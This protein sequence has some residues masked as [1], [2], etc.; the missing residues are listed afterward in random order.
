MSPRA[1]KTYIYRDERFR[2]SI[3]EATGRFRTEGIH[4]IDPYGRKFIPRGVNFAGGP[5]ANGGASPDL[6]RNAEVVEG[7]KAWGGNMIR[8]T[9]YV[10]RR[11]SW[12]VMGEAL[13]A[14]KAVAQATAEVDAYVDA[15]INFW[16]TRGVAVMVEAHDLTYSPIQQ[17]WLDD[18]TDYWL[19]FAA[20][21][22]HDPY[23]W[24]NLANEPNMT[25][26][27][28]VSYFGGL[29]ADV[30][31]V[32]DSIIVLDGLYYASDTGQYGG[33]PAPFLRNL[34]PPL[35]AEHDGLVFSMHN[36]GTVNGYYATEARVDAWIRT[37]HA[38][39]LPILIGEVG[40]PVGGTANSG[41]LSNERSAAI[42]S[43]AAGL[44]HGV[45]VF[46]WIV[47]HND[48]Y[49]LEGSGAQGHQ[50]T[51]VFRPSANLNEAGQMF[52]DYLA[53]AAVRDPVHAPS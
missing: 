24:L 50:V 37:N 43:C 30:R 31:E 8:L 52:K 44:R 17:V 18:L 9:S 6:S 46:W 25:A 23:V 48:G 45:G 13:A 28:W 16:R 47:G 22:A 11:H 51:N 5:K 15:I 53:A 35:Q 20:R 3:F 32:T 34:A 26:Q 21:W 2:P 41:S 7:F 42:G 39:G 14:G 38:A 19:R 10:T 12:S 1:R 33:G 29:V 49:R 40:W 4:I 36:Y 27:Q